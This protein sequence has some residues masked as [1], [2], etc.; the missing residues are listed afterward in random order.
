MP[1]PSDFTV[2]NHGGIALLYP[3]TPAATAWCECFLP[4]DSTML[5]HSYAVEP[6]YVEGILSGIA[7][8]GLTLTC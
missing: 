8:E 6:R 4:E 5:G 3:A 1:E 7:Y 2:T